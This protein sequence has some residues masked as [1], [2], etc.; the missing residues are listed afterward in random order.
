[1]NTHR[2]ILVTLIAALAL[3]M[4][5]R[6]TYTQKLQQSGRVQLK[7]DKTIDLLVNGREADP[8]VT[9]VAPTPAKPA[10]PTA[11]KPDAKKPSNTLNPAPAKQTT[12]D[13]PAEKEPVATTPTRTSTS[14]TSAQGYR[15]KFFMGGSSRADKEK[16]QVT[17]KEFKGQ[18][19]DVA[20]YMNFVSPHWICV[21]GDFNTQSE[22]NAF[23]HRAR[24][25]GYDTSSMTV[26]K[27]K[28]RVPV[29]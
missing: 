26:V 14:Y 16:A 11:T 28:I 23:I 27:T 13:T 22:A 1:M 19:P 17:G 20:V 21:A 10:K 6:L 7:Q 9:P 5:A 29:Y 3:P 8:V 18:F 4:A 12:P 2:I 25:S 15:V 24:A